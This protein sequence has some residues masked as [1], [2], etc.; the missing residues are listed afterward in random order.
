[1]S[2]VHRDTPF[3]A[4]VRSFARL[5]NACAL[6]VE[7][8]ALTVHEGAAKRRPGGRR[9]TVHEGAA[10]R[11]PG[12][13]RI[14]ETLPTTEPAPVAAPRRLVLE[15]DLLPAAL[16]RLGFKDVEVREMVQRATGATLEERVQ[17]ALRSRK[18]A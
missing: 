7:G 2:R 8:L 3:G 4:L 10:K 16:K 14:T 11:R 18:S 13:R 12:G 1:M 5:V 9:I 17:S 6:L 15:D